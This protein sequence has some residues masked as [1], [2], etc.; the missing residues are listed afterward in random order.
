MSNFCK[1]HSGLFVTLV[2]EKGQ[3]ALCGALRFMYIILG[4]INSICCFHSSMKGIRELSLTF[5]SVSNCVAKDQQ[6]I[7]IRAACVFL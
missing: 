1:H 5:A 6:Y 4:W 2:I 3:A 7:Q